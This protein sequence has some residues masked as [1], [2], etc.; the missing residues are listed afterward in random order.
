RTS[1]SKYK[2]EPAVFPFSSVN[3]ASSSTIRSNASQPPQGVAIPGLSR[4]GTVGGRSLSVSNSSLPTGAPHVHNQAI[5]PS[6]SFAVAKP[7]DPLSSPSLPFAMDYKTSVGSGN[8]FASNPV[9]GVFFPECHCF[10]TLFPKSSFSN[11]I[12]I[13]R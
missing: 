11:L 12:P 4:G 1:A 5:S 7:Q 3:E 13:L 8:G 10:Q 9:F 2:H 6:I